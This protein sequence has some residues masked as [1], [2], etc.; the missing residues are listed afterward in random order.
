MTIVNSVYNRDNILNYRVINMKKNSKFYLTL[1]KTIKILNF[2]ANQEN[3]QGVRE[4]AR[5]LDINVSTVHRILFTLK[6]YEYVK[7]LQNK[8][9]LGIR[10]FEMGNIF[11]RRLDIQ[12]NILPILNKL[13]M[14]T[15]E[16]VSLSM[17]NK[18]ERI[19]LAI[20]RS[21]NPIQTVAF[22]GKREL[23]HKSA[24]G[25]AIMAYLPEKEI[26]WIIKEKKLPRYTN[27]TITDVGKLKEELEKTRS[28]GYAIDLGE[29]E[30]EVNC[31]AT[32]VFN[33]RGEVIASISTSVP[34]YRFSLEKCNEFKD[35]ICKAAREASKSLGYKI[36]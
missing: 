24:A 7:K 26:D 34:A 17:Y 27:N 20:V 36:K 14:E 18:G 5:Q 23:L 22:I 11:F 2:L 31:I 30:A 29:G 3:P 12:D 8:Y 15:G 33:Y 21:A 19:Y 25:K 1:E 32:P 10:L 16:T 9:S 28:R 35:F 4:I 13:M 6:E